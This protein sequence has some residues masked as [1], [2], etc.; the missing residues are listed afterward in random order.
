MAH[1][2][3]VIV[4]NMMQPNGLPNTG[5]GDG[6]DTWNEAVAKM[7]AMFF[8]LYQLQAAKSGTPPISVNTVGPVV[9]APEAM[10]GGHI[11]RSG[12]KEP[13]TDTTASAVD[14]IL[15]H[16]DSVVGSSWGLRIVNDTDV[17]ETL[18]A[19]AG[20]SFH[21]FINAIPPHSAAHFLVTQTS[22]TAIAMHFMGTTSSSGATTVCS[23]ATSG[24]TTACSDRHTKRR[25]TSSPIR[26]AC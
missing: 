2:Q 18:M 8:E 23:A 10:V 19:G 6:G 20:V 17:R 5:S 13:F 11:V 7:N 24:A 9:M 3:K 4:P 12:Q 22:A 16:P 15:A 1:T 14:I 26:L 21:D 25:S